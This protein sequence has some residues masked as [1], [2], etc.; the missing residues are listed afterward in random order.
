MTANFGDT[1]DKSM[2]LQK[3]VNFF[4][5]L[6]ANAFRKCDFLNACPAEPIHGA[7]PL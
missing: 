1:S 3:A 5:Q 2:P 6:W 4:G 7:E